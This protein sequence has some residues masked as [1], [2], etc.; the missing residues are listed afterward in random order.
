M[1]RFFISLSALVFFSLQVGNASLQIVAACPP[2]PDPF[3][4]PL[5]PGPV[6]PPPNTCPLSGVTSYPNYLPITILNNSTLSNSDIYVAVLIDSKKKYLSFSTVGGH[7]L[8]AITSFAASTYLSSTLY[9][10]PL[11]GFENTG[12]NQY[13]FYIPNTGKS[14]TPSSNPL[15]SSQIIISV[16]EPLTYFIDHNGILGVPAENEAFNDN[17]FILNDKVEFDLGSNNLNRLN[18]NLTGVDFFGL[19][20][21]VQ[22]NYLFFF[23]GN[24]TPNCAFTGWPSTVSFSDVF[25]G[26]RAA[27]DSLQ[28]PFNDH[29]RALIATY[30]NPGGGTSDIRIFS[31]KT[32]MTPPV[33]T[34]TNPSLVDFPTTYFLSSILSDPACTW[35]NAVWSGLTHSGQTAYYQQKTTPPHTLILDATVK[36]AAT[37]TGVMQN[38]GAFSF[39]IHGGP[40]KGKTMVIPYPKNSMAFFTGAVSDYDPPISGSASVDTQAQ[41][42]KVFAT[43]IIGAFFPFNSLA[44]TPPVTVTQDYLEAHSEDYFQNNALLESLLAGCTC[45]SNNP[46]FDFYSRTLLTLGSPNLFYTSAYSDELGTDG[47][48]VIV[49]LNDKNPDA[50]ILLTLN[51]LAGVTLPDP[52]SDPNTYSINVQFNPNTTVEYGTSA[53]GPWGAIPATTPGNTF[54]LRV[55]YTLPPYNT[56]GLSFITQV[57]PTAKITHPILPYPAVIT[58]TGLT[59]TLSLGGP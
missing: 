2:P 38:N 40:D 43:M 6:P 49:G 36:E 22:A 48:I 9:S 51:S 58:T 8:G 30:N 46:W 28:S 25:T 1:R 35:F 7:K 53:T 54:F 11:D 52:Y 39:T 56:P 17:Y 14:G 21:S 32:A 5:I 37:A 12:T 16:G 15:P 18:M 20:L 50:T 10:T 47:T 19:P 44:T 23:G 57:S 26:Y 27:L 55:K 29:W 42:F 34:Q 13:T 33:Q 4:L 41:V 31:P 3:V 24:L 45:E 59:T